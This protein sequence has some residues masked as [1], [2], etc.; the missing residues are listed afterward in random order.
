MIFGGTIAEFGHLLN[1]VRYPVG[2]LLAVVDVC[3]YILNL[4]RT[5]LSARYIRD[6]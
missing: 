4:V 3:I 1:E 5:N 2:V 6:F